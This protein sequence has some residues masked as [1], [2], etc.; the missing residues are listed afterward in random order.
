MSLAKPWNLC[1]IR[2]YEEV[3]RD[4]HVAGRRQAGLGMALHIKIDF[5]R[6]RVCCFAST[7]MSYLL[8][9]VIENGID[10]RASGDRSDE[11]ESAI[12]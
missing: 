6:S 3:I 2:A 11:V 5:R 9:F 8:C 12:K 10:K 4:R 7:R 1:L